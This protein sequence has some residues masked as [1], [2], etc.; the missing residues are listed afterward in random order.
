MRVL[1]TGGTGFVGLFVVR[2]LLAA[3]HD[4]LGPAR[5]EAFETAYPRRL[6][7]QRLYQWDERLVD[8]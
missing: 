5:S 2:G 7:A 1:V 3:G 4:V 8:D 6:S